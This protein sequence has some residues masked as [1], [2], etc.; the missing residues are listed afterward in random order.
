MKAH[1]LSETLGND[2]GDGAAGSLQR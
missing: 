2:R 1:R